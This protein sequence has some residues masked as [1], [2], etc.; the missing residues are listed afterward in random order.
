M[1]KILIIGS[2][3][4]TTKYIN[5]LSHQY[6]IDI[7][8]NRKMQNVKIN[9]IYSLF[10]LPPNNYDLLIIA[11]KTSDHLNHYYKYRHLAFKCLIEK[12]L[13]ISKNEL[14]DSLIEDRNCWMSAPLRFSEKFDEI[15]QSIKLAVG[16]FQAI[17]VSKSWFPDWRPN[18]KIDDGYWNSKISGG[19]IREQLH[20]LDYICLLFGFPKYVK[21]H[22]VNTKTF[23]NLEIDDRTKIDFEY[24]DGSIVHIYI[25][26]SSKK[27]E[28]Y[29]YFNN[30]NSSI[31]YDF[32]SGLIIKLD[33]K[34]LESKKIETSEKLSL[35]AL[36]EKQIVDCLQED[37]EKK[38]PN[39]HHSISL[40]NLVEVLEQ[41]EKLNMRLEFSN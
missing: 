18:R 17:A 34:T 13:N 25:D 22:S 32:L 23:E 27:S 40:V 28:R 36:L 19:I 41:S 12:P 15:Q 4:I 11:S 8:T 38:L 30:V 33:C 20:E 37:G 2:G 3:S 16:P 24:L 5:A 31:I 9:K 35:E 7:V 6:E 29:F 1:K 26:I 21:C 39:M 10:D 14:S